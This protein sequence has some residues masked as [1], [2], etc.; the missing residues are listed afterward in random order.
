[1]KKVILFLSI[2]CLLLTGCTKATENEPTPSAATEVGKTGQPTPQEAVLATPTPAPAEDGT[3]LSRMYVDIIKSGDYFM[4]AKV[5]ADSGVMDFSVSV[6]GESTAME[7]AF[8]GTMQSVVV[9]DGVTYMID[10]SSKMIITSQA[11]VANSASGMAGDALSTEGIT[12]TGNGTGAFSGESLP[13]D[14]YKTPNGGTMRFYFRNTALAG[15]ENVDNEVTT[16][17]VI[18]EISAGHRAEMHVIPEDY[19]LLDMA[20]LGG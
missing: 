7:T 15:I 18:E 17:Y 5:Q 12:F 8:G 16:S 14:E 1:M 11:E 9:R 2:F 13:Y 20:S 19:Q 3:P 10:H 6:N 4:K